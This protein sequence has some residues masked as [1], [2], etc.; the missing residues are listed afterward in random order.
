M[1]L[2]PYTK[3]RYCLYISNDEI[4]SAILTAYQKENIMKKMSG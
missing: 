4:F 1:E 3:I 2:T